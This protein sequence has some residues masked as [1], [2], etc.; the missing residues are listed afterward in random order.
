MAEDFPVE[1]AAPARRHPVSSAFLTLLWSFAYLARYAWRNVYPLTALAAGVFFLVG[2]DQT[3]EILAN[4]VVDIRQLARLEATRVLHATFFVLAMAVW[5][6]FTWYAM[7]LLSSTSFPADRAPHQHAHRFAHWANEELPRLAPFAAVMM[8]ACSSSIFLAEEPIGS[9]VALLAA[10]VVPVTWAVASLGDRVLGR[11]IK[12]HERPYPIQL[13]PHAL[14]ALA[15]MAV[16]WSN[17]PAS[18]QPGQHSLGLLFGAATLVFAWPWWLGHKNRK[19][20]IAADA[21]MVGTGIAWIISAGWYA[22]DHSGLRVSALIL[23]LASCGFWLISRRRDFFHLRSDPGTPRA[24]IAPVTAWAIVFSVAALVSLAVAFGQWPI[25]LGTTFGTLAIL[26]AALGLWSFVGA[27]W[28]YLPKLRGWPALGWVPIA[29]LVVFGATL[30]HSLRDTSYERSGE[31]RPRLEGHFAQWRAALPD[32]GEK[33]PVFFVAAAGGGLRAA[34]W[35]ATALAA[36]DDLTCGEFGR[37]VYVYSG[38][39]GGS[40]GVAAYLA[41][42]QV[43]EAKKLENPDNPCMRGRREEMNRMLGRDFLGPVVG[44]IVFAELGAR[45]LH[46]P[47]DNDRGATLARS[48]SRAW[49]EEFGKWGAAG[50]FDEAFLKAFAPIDAHGK[51][52]PAVYL[53]TTG[54]DSGQRIVAGNVAYLRETIP[55]VVDLMRSPRR[56]PIKADGIPVREAVLNS[57]RF[58]YV[59]PA[60][61]VFSCSEEPVENQCPDGA[62]RIWERLVDGGYFENSGVATVNDLV[63]ALAANG[64]PKDD[65]YVIVIDNANAPPLAC[66]PPNWP[67]ADDPRPTLRAE[68]PWLSGVTAPIETFLRV[69]EARARQ[70][71]RRLR[72]DF[73]CDRNRLIDWSLYGDWDALLEAGQ[74]DPALGWFLSTRSAKWMLERVERVTQD[75]PFKLAACHHGKL[76]KEVRGLL[77]ERDFPR[78]HCPALRKE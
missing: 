74:P 26:F 72:S 57:A 45:L 65:L 32:R 61:T 38:V 20:K 9:W 34:L 1:P 76:S 46:T 16:A 4:L 21:G 23:V 69:R 7:R 13:V 63:R 27:L 55:G 41:Q 77:G 36:A 42:R 12:L 19:W 78:E 48:W 11:W 22:L 56:A 28:V 68:L 8:V 3:R 67:W 59:S 30:D 64:V 52:G 24:G 66:P 18:T 44:S 15:A 70:E 53:N 39:S 37:H 75:L 5:A 14:L 40:L 43:W 47:L 54:A 58:T 49:D 33:R 73:A 2:V 25:E 17:L 35:T 50:R 6:L 71:I 29:W 31:R 51:V 60:G 10:G 62:E